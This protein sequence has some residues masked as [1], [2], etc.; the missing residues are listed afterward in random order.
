MLDFLNRFRDSVLDKRG[1]ISAMISRMR[2]YSEIAA[3]AKEETLNFPESI[4]TADRIFCIVNNIREWPRCETCGNA[5]ARSGMKSGS[6]FRKFC[7][8]PCSR[9]AGSSTYKNAQETNLKRYGVKSNLTLPAVLEAKRKSGGIGAQNPEIA[10]KIKATNIKK[11]GCENVFSNVEVRQKIANTHDAKY[12]GNFQTMRLGKKIGLLEDAG[13]C[14]NLAKNHC[15]SSISEM[16]GVSS[17]TVYKYF[18]KHGITSFNRQRSNIEKQVIDFLTELGIL[19]IVQGDRKTISPLEIDI[20][21]PDFQLGIELHGLYW[22]SE[23]AGCRP[24]YHLRKMKAAQKAGIR[25]I[26]IFESE[27]VLSREIVKSRL[28]NLF[29][30]SR[31]IYARN[32]EVECISAKQKSAFLNKNHIQGDCPSSINLGL[33]YKKELVAIATFGKTRFDKTVSFELLRFCSILGTTTVGGFSKLL[34]NFKKR[35]SGSIVSYCDNRWSEGN[36]YSKNGFDFVGISFPAYHY[37]HKSSLILENRQKYQ[38]HKLEALLPNFDKALS[39]WENMQNAGYNRI[40]DCGTT[41]W[42]LK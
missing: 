40:W 31:K 1:R 25:L 34:V 5:T 8:F 6:L 30:K 27:W 11:Y 12:G 13:Y 38:K 3:A 23:K 18:E 37:F 35:H 41:K 28:A 2:N 19:H 22:H 21:L 39:E 20:F 32:C 4:G 36:L 15:M 17:G 29:G 26:Q 7:S 9:V 10:Q 24:L 16:L 14:R 33:F 42:V